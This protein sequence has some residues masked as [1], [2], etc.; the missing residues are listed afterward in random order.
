MPLL[1]VRMRASLEGRH[2]SG[3]ERIVTE[4]KLQDTVLELLKRP[5]RFDNIVLTVERLVSVDRLET[6][7]PV[8]SKTLKSVKEARD[9]ALDLLVRS[10]IPREIGL[11]AIDLLSKG[12]SPSGGVMR[13]A[14]VMDVESGERLEPDMYRGVRTVRVDW[15]DRDRVR[16]EIVRAGYTERTLDALAIAT[17]NAYCG[18]LAEICWSDDPDYVTGYVASPQ[19][20]YVR[21]TPLKERGD[22]IGGRVYFIRREDLEGFVECVER[23]A[24]IIKSWR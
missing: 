3:A 12:P 13:G 1:S 17:K 24:L 11:K 7:L 6:S 9:L 15:E 20:G 4:G 8:T 5:R 18:A 10:G 14:V 22:P 16:E 19:I 2:V 21:I 23:R